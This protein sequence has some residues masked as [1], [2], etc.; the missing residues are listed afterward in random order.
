MFHQPL[1]FGNGP[2]FLVPP[3]QLKLKPSLHGAWRQCDEL[4]ATR[5]C[6]PLR[7]CASTPET[8]LDNVLLLF[9][10]GLVQRHKQHGCQHQVAQATLGEDGMYNR[11]SRRLVKTSRHL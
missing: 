10:Q 3:G 8:L 1:S 6:G 4:H 2:S 11:L 7:Q 5:W 9:K